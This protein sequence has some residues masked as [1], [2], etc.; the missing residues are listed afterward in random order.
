MTLDDVLVRLQ[1]DILTPGVK[2]A[3]R[4]SRVFASDLMSDVLAFAHSGTLLLTGLANIHVVRTATLADIAA[5]VFV[6]GKRPADDIIA[7]AL[8]N[9]LP[10]ASTPLP[11]FEACTR[12]GAL[13]DGK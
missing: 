10:L 7:E 3:H 4:F 1:G 8:K 5:V 11:M 13:L 9:D 12:M 6:Q 2:T